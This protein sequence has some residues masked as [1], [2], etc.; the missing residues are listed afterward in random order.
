MLRKAL[1]ALIVAAFASSAGLEFAALPAAAAMPAG[2]LPVSVQSDS[3]I[4]PVAWVYVKKRHG[5]RFK[6]KR[7]PYRYRYG[8]WYYTRPW[9]TF[10][11][12]PA[13]CVYLP[14]K[15]GPRFK[16][17][18]GKYAYRYNGWYYARPWWSVCVG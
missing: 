18:H 3:N 14:A 5:N 13:G 17:K 16:Y 1:S 7:G 2:N 10:G 15:H 12:G 11:I 9:W 6:F 8:G 4:Q